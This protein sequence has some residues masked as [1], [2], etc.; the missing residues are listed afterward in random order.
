[1]KQILRDIFI[2]LPNIPLI[3]VV[4][5]YAVVRDTDIL[6][7]DDKSLKE[8]IVKH[9]DVPLLDVMSNSIALCFWLTVVCKIINNL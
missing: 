6:E 3:V 1:M 5:I 7:M 4:A 8:E 2:L 9:L